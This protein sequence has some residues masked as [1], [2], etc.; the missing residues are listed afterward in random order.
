MRAGA[1]GSQTSVI[2]APE[3]ELPVWGLGASSLRAADDFNHF[4]APRI[5][6]PEVEMN[7]I[8][9]GT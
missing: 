3:L 2:E 1:E 4:P 6:F 8:R 5:S 7:S 9:S